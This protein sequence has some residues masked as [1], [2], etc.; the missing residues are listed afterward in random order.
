M[1]TMPSVRVTV[2][3]VWDTIRL[4]LSPTGTAAQLKREA[5]LAARVPRDPDQYEMKVG[6]ALIRDE[7]QTLAAIGVPDDGAVIVLPRRRHPVR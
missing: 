7:S 2:L 6:G 5:L 1:T 3:D 4:P